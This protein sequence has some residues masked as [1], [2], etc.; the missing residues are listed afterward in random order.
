[1]QNGCITNCIRRAF[2][3]SLLAGRRQV[4]EAA[5]RGPQDNGFKRGLRLISTHTSESPATWSNEIKLA[6][7]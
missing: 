4:M 2:G 3:M 6:K 7:I 1:M 5:Q